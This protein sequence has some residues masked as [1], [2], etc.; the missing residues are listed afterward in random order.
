MTSYLQVVPSAKE[1]VPLSAHTTYRLGGPADFLVEVKTTDEFVQAVIA[2]RH[3]G[4]PLLILGHGSN[5]LVADVGFRGVVVKLKAQSI[6]Q[7]GNSVTAD[8]GVSMGRLAHW[9]V[10]RGLAGIE[11][12]VGIPGTVGGS[13]RGNAGCFGAEIKDVVSVVE[14]L[15][16]KNE[17]RTLA[18]ANCAFGYRDSL[19]KHSDSLILNATFTLHD[20]EAGEGKELLQ[21]WGKKR[22]E[23]QDFSKPSSG[24]A[25]K[26]PPGN[27]AG[28][29]IDD[30]GLKGLKIGGAQVSERHAN[31][32]IHDGSAKAADVLELLKQVR[33]KVKDRYGIE[34]EPEIMLAG[35]S[36]EELKGI[37]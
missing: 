24:C 1:G 31:F 2:A 36:E 23:E 30:L 22:L 12:A 9:A 19:F 18:N 6:V 13:V 17:R 21:Q 32:L 3:L 16:S 35:F 4:L 37:G 8:A 7:N 34:L 11:F 25:F 29:M 15:T 28:K 10:D 33:S 27:A 26:N 5:I 14:I 20:A